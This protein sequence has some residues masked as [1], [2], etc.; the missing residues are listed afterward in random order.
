MIS[1]G[2]NQVIVSASTKKKYNFKSI[3]NLK[4]YRNAPNQTNDLSN[5]VRSKLKR[6]LTNWMHTEQEYYTKENAANNALPP[7]APCSRYCGSAAVPCNQKKRA[8]L[9]LNER[10]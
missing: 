7:I 3:Q 6:L 5:N 9:R 1:V 8:V 4:Q 10:K 2:I